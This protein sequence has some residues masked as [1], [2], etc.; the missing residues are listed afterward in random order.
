VVKASDCVICGSP[1]R[2]LRSA[3]VAPFL[4]RRIWNRPPF[5]VHLAGCDACGFRFYNPRLE[6]D[7][8]ARLYAD[9]RSPEY[10]QMRCDS[11]PWYTE[12]LNYS[13]ASPESYQARRA[14]LQAIL[15]RYIKPGRVRRV[16][17]Y[18]G[19]HGDLVCGLIP[20][21]EAFVYDISGVPPAEGVSRVTNPV[22]CVPDLIVNSNVLE[23]VGFPQRLMAQILQAAPAGALI[24]LEVPCE[25]PLGFRH[26]AKR[27]IQTGLMGLLRPGLALQV[28]RPSTL[29]M[30]HEHV[31]YFTAETLSKL[32]Q[33]GRCSVIA[34]GRYDHMAWC[35]GQV[36]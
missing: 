26:L 30:M 34:A 28:V 23:H 12:K 1:V 31:N 24:F 17:D 9:Y 33:A 11:E 36:S 22:E 21:A 25:N 19:D 7:E 13:L 15:G 6:P 35:L 18:G 32:M 29:Y 10:R 20:G 5:T 3:L 4:A 27:T 14:G 2:L 16:L 8:E